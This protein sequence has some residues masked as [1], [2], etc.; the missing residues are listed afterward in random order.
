MIKGVFTI[1]FILLCCLPTQ[2]QNIPSWK[3]TDVVKYYSQK[4]DSV[5]VINFWATWCKPCVE[6]LPY[7]QSVSKKYA[8][9]KVKLLL[10]SLDLASFYP[11]KIA[12]FA[13]KQNITADIAWLN[14]TDADYFCNQVDK[15]WSGS[16]PA[17]IIVN[18]A[19]GYKQFYEQQFEEKEF[20]VEL[21]KA[22]GK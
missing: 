14:E 21:K 22:L 4:T 6:E 1:A 15:K 11:A 17:T 9:K 13:K 12:S 10:L 20:E 16:I 2:A 3:I 18:A 19:T 8:D 7:L 5:Y